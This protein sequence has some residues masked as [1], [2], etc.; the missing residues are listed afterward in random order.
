MGDAS[1]PGFAQAG[2]LM[3]VGANKNGQ[4]T[5]P[6]LSMDSMHH[7]CPWTG[8]SAL[9]SHPVQPTT[10]CPSIWKLLYI[11]AAFASRGTYEYINGR[12]GCPSMLSYYWESSSYKTAPMTQQWMWTGRH[13]TP[14]PG[15]NLD[16]VGQ[17]ASVTV[18][19][20]HWV[21]CMCRSSLAICWCLLIGLQALHSLLS[22]PILQCYN[23]SIPKNTLTFIRC[24]VVYIQWVYTN[25]LH[26][27][28]WIGI[29]CIIR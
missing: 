7:P 20:N 5:D 1:K 17:P 12:K 11:L 15:S 2:W 25:A 13:P 6:S 14:P 22:G 23:N 18:H 10:K 29:L 28:R 4:G 21:I 3:N 19:N 16:G 26:T 8:N 9:K 24:V 27:V